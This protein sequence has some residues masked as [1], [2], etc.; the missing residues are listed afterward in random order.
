M[1]GERNKVGNL[2]SV[3]SLL[4]NCQWLLAVA[5][6]TCR[7]LWISSTHGIWCSAFYKRTGW[8]PSLI[9]PSPDESGDHFGG[10]SA[11]NRSP[12]IIRVLYSRT[13]SFATQIKN[14][15]WLSKASPF[16]GWTDEIYG[17]PSSRRAANNME[18]N[19][20][21]QEVT[22][23]KGQFSWKMD[24]AV[25]S[26]MPHCSG[27]SGFVWCHPSAVHGRVHRW[28]FIDTVGGLALYHFRPAYL[29]TWT[30]ANW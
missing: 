10:L 30:G 24:G 14:W 9:Q 5:S 29:W 12:L 7:N 18:T 25:L 4:A 28:C 13:C 8:H 16:Q 23:I 15:R 1:R 21:N 27:K 19:M 20:N 2:Y 3:Q 6:R 17:A 26:V 11:R 22:W